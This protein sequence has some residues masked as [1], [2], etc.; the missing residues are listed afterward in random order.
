MGHPHHL[1]YGDEPLADLAV[2]NYGFC[3]FSKILSRAWR[4]GFWIKL[5]I[6][7]EK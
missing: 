1:T 4:V 6:R 3:C 7:G 2:G 5:L